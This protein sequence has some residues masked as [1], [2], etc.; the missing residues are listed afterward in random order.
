M[1][2]GLN[3]GI[4]S[5]LVELQENGSKL[6]CV[7]PATAKNSKFAND[8]QLGEMMPPPE[9]RSN[10]KGFE[11]TL[12]LFDEKGN[13]VFGKSVANKL[14]SHMISSPENTSSYLVVLKDEHGNDR[15]EI[16]FQ[17]QNIDNSYCPVTLDCSTG[18]SELNLS[19]L[20]QSNIFSILG[21]KGKPINI[22]LEENDK[23]LEPHLRV[24]NLS[25]KMICES[26]GYTR[27]SMDND[28]FPETGRY[29]V[30]ASDKS[31]NDIG[32]FNISAAYSD[33]EIRT[34]DC[35]T[36]YSGF[37]PMSTASLSVFVENDEAHTF[38]WSTGE[39]SS[40]IEVQPNESTTYSVTVTN[41]NG[42]MGVGSAYVEVVDV[43][44]A[45]RKV[46]IC[47]VNENTGEHREMCISENGVWGHLENGLG[48]DQ[49]HIGPCDHVSVC[50][51]ESGT[52]SNH[53]EVTNR[54]ISN[55]GENSLEA[56]LFPNP[57]SG[58]LNLNLSISDHT[59]STIQILK[60]FN[61]PIKVDRVSIAS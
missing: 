60:A 54:S 37:E 19:G 44:C 1:S 32:E 61:M 25:G 40:D 57:S 34:T 47:H 4:G 7:G 42:C 8:H 39:T 58:I 22:M 45:D 24:Y 17:I 2:I 33:M 56:D 55:T 9:L 50:H 18:I 35:Q 14:I 10:N 52:E 5:I 23:S 13:L 3:S 36:V 11:T 6:S 48:H 49:C 30:L 59:L 29:I 15:S 43:E 38:L 46:Q 27:V 28:T 12:Q 41:S 16:G 26:F 51:S 53:A 21:E 20:A 31:G